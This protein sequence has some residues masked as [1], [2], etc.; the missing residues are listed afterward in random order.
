LLVDN[1][2]FLSNEMALAA[3]S[4]QSIALNAHGNDVKIRNCRV[5]RFRHFAV[6]SGSGNLIIGNHFFQGDTQSNATRTAGIVLTRVNLLT[7]ITGNY[8][9][10][11]FIL[12]TN[13]HSAAPN[14]NNQFSFGGL[15]MTGNFFLCSNT[16]SAFRFFIVRPF[17]SGHFLNGLQVSGNVFRTLSGMIARVEQADAADAPL[18]ASKHRNVIWENNAY[19]GITT[20]TE[21]PLV[22]RHNQSTAAREWTISTGGKLPF[23]G[24]ART[25]PSFTMEG[26]PRSA[27]NE[28]RT[29]MPYV[30]VEQGS[31]RNAV[32]LSWP[33]DTRGR[34]VVTIRVDTPN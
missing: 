32:R 24:W 29:G 28:V 33:S 10:N 14:W 20:S 1:C 11:C 19:H 2:Q 18:D 5:V 13:E 3:T 8:I 23:G 16:T 34:A 6:L 12:L 26:V 25:V 21:S 22:V 17:G 9:D 31:A 4:R 7:T 27:G 30:S 15:T